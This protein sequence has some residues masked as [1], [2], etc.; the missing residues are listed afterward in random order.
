M[1]NVNNYKIY[2]KRIIIYT[3]I[4]F[5]FL[6][7]SLIY[8]ISNG[9]VQISLNEIGRNIF[10]KD[11]GY[12]FNIIWNIRLPRVITAIIA[13]IGLSIS[14]A[15]MQCLLKNPLSSP[16]TL[17]ISQAAAFGAAFSIVFFRAGS[18]QSNVIIIDNPYIITISAFFWALLSIFIILLIAK[19]KGVNP[20]TIILAGVAMGS[21]FTAG[22]TALQYFAND[23]EIASIIFWTFGDLGRTSWNTLLIMSL[24]IIITFIYF[25]LNSW[26]YNALNSGDETAR[27]L[28]VN[29]DSLR[30]YGMLLSSL[31]TSLI[32][33]FI[34]VIGFIGLIVPHMVRR[35]IG[36][37]EVF[38]LPLSAIT[39]GLL[40]LI[41]DTIARTVIAP[42][43]LPVG[44]LTSFLGG[45][46]FIYL[47]LKGRRY[48]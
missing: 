27:S 43:V 23:V 12:I 11:T 42:V 5:L 38:L 32:V 39:G 25:I 44:I 7:L 9:A 31:I 6:F 8:S 3:F 20:E 36:G 14:G 18:E 24:A 40:L 26:N 16:F 21:I 46:V 10:K 4:T 22:T 19:Y 37:N 35:L 30:V 33:S 47:V 2:R 1:S 29:V 45:P 48:W 13:G 41:S 17:G 15:V 28:G 34:G